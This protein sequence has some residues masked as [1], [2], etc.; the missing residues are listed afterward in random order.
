MTI[1]SA[2]RIREA[3]RRRAAPHI[4]TYVRFSDT[5]KTRIDWALVTSANI[6]KQAWGDAINAAGEVRVCSYELGVL[7]W[8]ELYGEGAKM[9]PTF[10]QDI[11]V[12]EDPSG[13]DGKVSQCGTSFALLGALFVS[14][15][16]YVSRAQLTLHLDS[17]W[18]QNAIRPSSRTI[19]E[20]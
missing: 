20:G 10:K 14:E 9:V 16:Q 18:F 2:L 13:V 7:L 5:S 11:P 6:S 12:V 8:P 17:C 15:L 19:L 4:K 1:D 3:G